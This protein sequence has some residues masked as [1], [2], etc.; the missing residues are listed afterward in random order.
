MADSDEE[1]FH[2]ATEGL[3]EEDFDTTKDEKNISKIET[4]KA[5][6]SEEKEIVGVDENEKILKP[7][8]NTK[9][10]AK[11]ENQ[12]TKQIDQHRL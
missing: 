12:P 5:K 3:E 11:Q 10:E 6:Y 2:S 8:D 7:S 9:V 1:C 4:S